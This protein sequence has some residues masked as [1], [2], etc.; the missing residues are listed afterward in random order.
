MP[1][2]LPAT[3][4]AFIDLVEKSHLIEPPRLDDYWARL[5]GCSAPDRP[6][7]LARRMVE[8]G[9]LTNFQAEQLLKGKYKGFTL[10]NYRILERI[11]RGG[12]GTVYLA[13]HKVMRHRVAVKVMPPAQAENPTARERFYRE[14]R[15][16]AMLSHPNLVRAHDIDC[17]A[18]MHYLVMEY[19]DGATLAELVARQGPLSA[20]RAAHYVGQA[21]I[22]L[23]YAHETA[24]MVHRDI[25]PG[26]LLV[27]RN[28]TVKILDMGLARIGAL[29]IF[30]A[31]A[32]SITRNYNDKSILGTADY[33][34]PEQAVNSQSADIRADI[35][36]LGATFYFLLT[37]QPP[38][39]TGSVTQ[40][41]MWHQM[42]EPAPLRQFRSDLPR[43]ITDLVGRMMSKTPELR[44]QQPC[45]VVEVLLPWIESDMPP[46]TE[47]EIPRLCPAAQGLTAGSVSKSSINLGARVA[48]NGSLSSIN[49]AAR[50]AGAA[51]AS[52]E[53]PVDESPSGLRAALSEA[54]LT[55]AAA[56]P[57]RTSLIRWLTLAAAAILGAA[58]GALAC[59]SLFGR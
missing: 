1:A 33:I 9:L 31:K 46:P 38:F 53:T 39:P 30:D 29:S 56:P 42:R 15:A 16:A 18:G 47:E 54:R 35:Y 8:D 3:I 59:W 12:M 2:A 24:G 57:K 11:G 36:S 20:D 37:G 34:A 58:G 10:G 28:G 23:Q 22:G 5:Q 7:R 19:V 51:K 48:R 50:T 4:A 52:A 40:K 41:L 43:E 6:H 13:E 25:K 14:A 44:P 21:A 49:L 26:N 27:D 55:P 32:D 45:E 17:A